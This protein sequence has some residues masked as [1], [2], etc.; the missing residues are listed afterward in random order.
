MSKPLCAH[1]DARGQG[2][3]KVANGRAEATA[4]SLTGTVKARGGVLG[5][6]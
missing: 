2:T 3:K 5:T 4:T 1:L 6:D